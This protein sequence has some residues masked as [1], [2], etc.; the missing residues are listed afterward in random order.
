MN[1]NCFNVIG[2]LVGD[3]STNSFILISLGKKIHRYFIKE[4]YENEI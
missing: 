3:K 2:V 1:Y 4:K